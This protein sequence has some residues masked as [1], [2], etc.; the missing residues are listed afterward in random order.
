[1]AEASTALA[2]VPVDDYQGLQMVVA[3]NEAQR[4]LQALQAFVQKN[5]KEGINQDYGVIPGT[6]TKPTLLKPGGEKLAEIYGLSWS[7]EDIT[8]VEDWERGFFFYRKK[9]RIFRQRDGTPICEGSGSCN[10]REDKYAYRWVFK[11]EIPAGVDIKKLVT[12][13][14]KSKKTGRPYTVYR[15]PNEDVYSL[16]NTIEKMAC[17]RAFVSAVIGATRSSGIFTQDIEDLPPEAFGPSPEPEDTGPSKFEQLLAAFD[18][19]HTPEDIATASAGVTAY[20]AHLTKVQL[21]TLKRKLQ[22]A[23]AR[24]AQREPG[25]DGDEDESGEST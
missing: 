16:V 22:E 5:M 4:R 13:E 8:A 3:P 17:K 1:M 9:C 21:H 24:I 6:G 18:A 7:Y 25:D 20:K 23:E 19:T 2:T 15:M 10:S 14:R 12:R 11:N